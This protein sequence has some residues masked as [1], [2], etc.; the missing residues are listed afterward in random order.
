MLVEGMALLDKWEGKP[1]LCATLDFRIEYKNL[2]ITCITVCR[3]SRKMIA[4]L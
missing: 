3:M 1:A 2:E 4:Y